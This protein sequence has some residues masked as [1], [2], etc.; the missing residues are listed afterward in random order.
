MNALLP[1]DERET[2][3]DH[4]ADR[5]AYLVVSFGLLVAVAWRSFA[6]HETAWDLLAL[7]VA[8]G[9]AGAGYRA[10]RGVA[11]RHWIAV[12]VASVVVGALAAA[13]NVLATRG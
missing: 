12:A 13:I 3:I 5:L 10:L 2:A 7:V 8:G 11:T 9:L 4:A 1:R 6:L